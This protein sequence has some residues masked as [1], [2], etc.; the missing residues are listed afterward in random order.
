[1]N[2]T[3]YSIEKLEDPTGIL[4]GNRYEIITY[5]QVDEEDEL[6]SENGL[7]V[8]II[9]AAI[10]NNSRI[11]QYNIYEDVTHKYLD[12]E[13]E[14]DELLYLE[15]FCKKAVIDLGAE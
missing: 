3:S 13:L 11:A 7:Y 4:E 6:Y 15:Q 10:E 1:M 5:M 9:F 2:I 14:E 12:F 8:K